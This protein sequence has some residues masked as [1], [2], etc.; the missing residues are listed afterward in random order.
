MVNRFIQLR[1]NSNAIPSGEAQ[2]LDVIRRDMAQNEIH[3]KYDAS[4]M[5]DKTMLALNT[6]PVDTI[7][8]DT[9]LR[10]DQ[11]EPFTHALVKSLLEW[12]KNDVFND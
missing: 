8:E 3:Q 5:S 9:K 7:H 2:F 12:F 6:I 11:G 1:A 10:C 4:Q